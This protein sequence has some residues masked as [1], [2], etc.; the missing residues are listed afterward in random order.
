[1]KHTT[2]VA[3]LFCVATLTIAADEGKTVSVDPTEFSEVYPA[4]WFSPS[5]GEITP[6]REKSE[7][8]PAQQYE[9]WIEPGDPEFGIM[10]KGLGF[11]LIGKGNDAFKN[12]SIP[13]EPSLKGAITHLMKKEQA[14]D[15]LVFYCKAKDSTCLIMVTT[16]DPKKEVLQFKWRLLI[17]DKDVSNKAMDSYKK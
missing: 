5:T 3:I 4:V 14:P 17:K 16:M 9:I 11:A 2:L 6:L 12:P 7:R 15:H 1:M 8:P 10:D 13:D